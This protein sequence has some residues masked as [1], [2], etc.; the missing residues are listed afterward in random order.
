[1]L[2]FMVETI[3]ASRVAMKNPNKMLTG[4]RRGWHFKVHLAQIMIVESNIWSKFLP[5]WTMQDE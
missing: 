2:L 1:M 3:P 5:R 4:W